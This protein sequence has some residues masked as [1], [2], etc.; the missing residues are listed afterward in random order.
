M[1][2]IVTD[3]T[4]PPCVGQIYSVPCVVDVNTLI[5]II[6]NFHADKENG[7]EY[8]HFHTDYRFVPDSLV[9]NMRVNSLTGVKPSIVYFPFV[10]LAE[11]N[12]SRVGITSA[13]PFKGAK[14]K[15]KKC[16]HKGFD[17]SQCPLKNG[18]RTCALHGLK[19]TKHYKLIEDSIV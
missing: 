9:V 1:L 7:Q 15:D 5:P 4:S 19:Y 17:L 3:L 16:L 18:V 12:T 2:E 13:Y 11:E 8:Y 14:A 6:D 10:C